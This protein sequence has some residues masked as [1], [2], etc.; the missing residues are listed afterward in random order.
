[1]SAPL[2]SDDV[3]RQMRRALFQTSSVL[4]LREHCRSMWDVLVRLDSKVKDLESDTKHL[5]GV[6][7]EKDNEIK[8]L[9]SRINELRFT[10]A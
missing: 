6:V 1:M 7:Q 8:T 9:R 10:N 2:I 5:Q 4:E 3:N